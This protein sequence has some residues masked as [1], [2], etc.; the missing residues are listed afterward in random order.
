MAEKKPRP[1]AG[2]GVD[3]RRVW[4][5]VVAEFE[6]NTREL[7]LLRLGCRQLDDVARLET[8]LERDGMTTVGAQG[9]PRLSAAV[10]E[11][12]QSRIAASRLIGELGL[13]DEADE[14]PWTARQLRAQRAVNFRW[15]RRD[16]LRERRANGT[17]S[18]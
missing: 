11:L 5:A 15:N 16:E 17:A 18:A 14:R 3:G 9:Q 8:L 4:L 2:L 13:P 1:P 10:G 6:L 12:R 7:E